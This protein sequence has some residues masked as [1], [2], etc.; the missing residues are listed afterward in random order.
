MLEDGLAL[1]VKSHKEKQVAKNSVSMGVQADEVRF[2][3]SLLSL[4]SNL[5]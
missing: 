5:I 4:V 3:L 1:L 2:V